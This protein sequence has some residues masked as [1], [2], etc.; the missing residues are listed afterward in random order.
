MVNSIIIVLRGDVHPAFR[1]DIAKHDR[2]I[3][4]LR[5]DS[6]L[7]WKYF[8]YFVNCSFWQIFNI[9]IK[10][11]EAILFKSSFISITIKN[12]RVNLFSSHQCLLPNLFNFLIIDS[13]T[14]LSLDSCPTNLYI[15]HQSFLIRFYFLSS[16]TFTPC[17]K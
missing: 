15:T 11:N 13:R 16:Y 2:Q 1:T 3:N 14:S 6:P 7:L 5:P 9:V 10:V 12:N 8:K 4:A 17:S